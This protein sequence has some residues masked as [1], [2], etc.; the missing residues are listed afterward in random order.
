MPSKE[1]FIWEN[2]TVSCGR[3][4]QGKNTLRHFL[5]AASF[6]SIGESVWFIDLPQKARVC[7]CSESR[8]GRNADFQCKIYDA[9]GWEL[10]LE[11]CH[12]FLGRRSI[13]V[14]SGRGAGGTDIQTDRGGCTAMLCVRWVVDSPVTWV[15]QPGGWLVIY[16]GQEIPL[17]P[18]ASKGWQHTVGNRVW[19]V[20]SNFWFN[21]E[22]L[23]MPSILILG[24]CWLRIWRSWQS[25]WHSPMTMVGRQEQT[26]CQTRCLHIKDKLHVLWNVGLKMVK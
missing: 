7:P 21:A 26:S 12:T 8:A 1:C 23:G 9:R 25:S 18:L 22:S 6:R 20:W 4:S 5:V 14:N 16:G 17:F 10:N 11:G 13:P 3:P 2:Q 24:D 15:Q 19:E